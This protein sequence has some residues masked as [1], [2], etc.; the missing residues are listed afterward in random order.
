M[1]I[2]AFEVVKIGT[3]FALYG[4]K[5]ELLIAARDR[6]K[7]EAALRGIEQPG[8][9]PEK[10]DTPAD[11]EEA[12]GTPLP[13]L[14][15]LSYRELKAIAKEQEIPGYHKMKREDLQA[16]IEAILAVAEEEEAEDE[17]PE[18]A[19]EDEDAPY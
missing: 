7:V 9:E 17:E 14:D 19:D 11:F 8:I 6:A 5:G 4:E 16:A 1:E 13:D 12:A 15:A 3:V 18:A 2:K 10:D